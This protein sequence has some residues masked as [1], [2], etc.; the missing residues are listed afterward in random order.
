MKERIETCKGIAK[1]AGFIIK[2]HKKT[3]LQDAAYGALAFGLFA[4]GNI[5]VGYCGAYDDV[6]ENIKETK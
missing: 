2:R 5:A 4:M 3:I 1:A 6:L